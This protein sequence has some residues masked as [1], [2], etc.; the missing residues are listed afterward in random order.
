MIKKL[1][2][3]LIRFYQNY[4]SVIKPPSCR[5]YPT[6]SEYAIIAFKRHGVI[7]GFFLASKRILKCHPLYRG[8]YVDL[9][10]NVQE[11]HIDKM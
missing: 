9:V 1:L 3:K 7:K 10:P 5:F 11:K 6:C 2:I 4:I 8:D